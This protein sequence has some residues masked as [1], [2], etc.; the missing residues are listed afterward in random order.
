MLANGLARK[1]IFPEVGDHIIYEI[2]DSSIIIVRSVSGMKS[3][4]YIIPAYI[5]A[6]RFAMMGGM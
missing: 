4:L 2:N 1:K 5:G 6:V 3:R